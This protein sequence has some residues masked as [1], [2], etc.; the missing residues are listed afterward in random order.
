MEAKN[1]CYP[2]AV[3]WLFYAFNLNLAVYFDSFIK[4][5]KLLSLLGYNL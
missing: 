4:K 5:R 1:I 2:P 3:Q